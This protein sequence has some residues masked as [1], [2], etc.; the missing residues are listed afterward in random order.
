[1]PVCLAECTIKRSGQ[2]KF[3]AKGKIPQ[4]EEKANIIFPA[5]AGQFPISN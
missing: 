3:I 2:P 5:V 1:M 4:G